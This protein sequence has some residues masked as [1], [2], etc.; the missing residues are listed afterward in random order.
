MGV[1]GQ[2]IPRDPPDFLSEQEKVNWNGESRWRNSS[3]D[4]IYTYDQLHGHIEAYTK[5]GRH[6]GPLD[7]KTGEKIGPAEKGRKIDV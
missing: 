6:I 4:R 7:V 1:P 2:Y 5:R 3:R